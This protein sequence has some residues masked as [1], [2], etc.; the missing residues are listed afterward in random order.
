MSVETPPAFDFAHALTVPFRMQ[1]G[2]RR[3]PEG[4][5]QLTPVRAGARHLREKLAVL[6]NWPDQ[7]L[8]TLPDFDAEPAL[9]A[10]ATHAA[11]EHPQAWT[12]DP[13]GSWRA[14]A[15]GCTVRPDGSLQTL[16]QAWVEPA[17]ALH[18]LPT[19][20]RRAALLALA[21]E[22]DFAIVD[23]ASATLPWLA[24]CLPSHWAPAQKL[25]QHFAQVHAPVADAELLRQSGAHLMALVSGPQ[26]WERFV[27]TL[28]RHPRLHAHPDRCDPAPWPETVTP[29]ALAA[30]C[31]WRTERQTFIPLPERRQAVFTIRVQSTRLPEVPFTPEQAQRLHDSLASMSPAV[32]DYRS[33]SPARDRLLHWLSGQARPLDDRLGTGP[34][35]A[36]R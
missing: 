19:A 18:A 11:A 1:P 32:L 26:R 28:T 21:F 23:G 35:A 30:Q 10:L 20:W 17:Q 12:V 16:P 34:A 3:L 36:W 4:A 22:E 31:W 24:V 14:R 29:D 7:A 33:L 15:L 2:L 5:V 27:W 25:G 6:L 13:D 8:L 9:Q